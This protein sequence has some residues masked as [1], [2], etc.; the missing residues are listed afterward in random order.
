MPK[1]I[2]KKR[3]QKIK[4]TFRKYRTRCSRRRRERKRANRRTIREH[5]THISNIISIKIREKRKGNNK[6]ID[7]SEDNENGKSK[8]EK[9]IRADKNELDLLVDDKKKSI[10]EFK[11]NYKDERFQTKNN[12]DFAIDPTNKNYKKMKGKKNY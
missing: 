8:E 10:G 1:I 4:N 7:S 12:I 6:D 2:I 5:I 9:D 3:I 11:F